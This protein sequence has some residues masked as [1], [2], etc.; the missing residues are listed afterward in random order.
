MAQ[1][2]VL[3]VIPR[4]YD[5]ALDEMRSATQA[6][7][8]ALMEVNKWLGQFVVAARTDRENYVSGPAVKALLTEFDAR[9]R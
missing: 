4:I 3:G 2:P 7:I 5:V 9:K 1:K 6:D 8:D